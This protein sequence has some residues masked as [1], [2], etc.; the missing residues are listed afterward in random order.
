MSHPSVARRL[1]L[2]AV[3]APLTGRTLRRARRLVHG[4]LGRRP[5][6]RRPAVNR[7]PPVEQRLPPPGRRQPGLKLTDVSC[8]GALTTNM[9]QIQTPF[10]DGRATP[11]RRPISTR[12]RRRPTSSPS[13]SGVTTSASAT[14]PAPARSTHHWIRRRGQLAE[15]LHHLPLLLR[16]ERHSNG[17]LPCAARS[18]GHDVA[19]RRQPRPPRGPRRP[20]RRPPRPERRPGRPLDSQLAGSRTSPS[21]ACTPTSRA[22]SSSPSR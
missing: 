13:A 17:R 21:G 12:S 6:R 20:R 3:A 19:D 14:S 9:T 5:G 18:R 15:L 10:P 7:L 16:P 22:R 8:A 11:R 2:L 1:P 4:R